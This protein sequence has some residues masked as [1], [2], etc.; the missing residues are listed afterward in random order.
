M[1]V[2]KTTVRLNGIQLETVYRSTWKGR[3]LPP[4]RLILRAK[5]VNNG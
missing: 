4:S 3:F 5:K 1:L 2:T